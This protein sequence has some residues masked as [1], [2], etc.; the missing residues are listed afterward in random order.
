MTAKVEEALKEFEKIVPNI[1]KQL[2][3]VQ[4][5]FS[6]VNITELKKKV[7]KTTDFVKSKL[8][9]I[10]KDNQNNEIT[11]KVNNQEAIKQ[12][13]QL[14]KEI[15]SLQKKISEREIKLK[16]TNSTLDSMRENTKQGVIAEMPDAGTKRINQQTELRLFSDNNYVKMANESDKLANEITRYNAQLDSAKD[17]MAGMKNEIT[18]ISMTQDQLSNSAS[19][20]TGKIGQSKTN[21][22]KLKSNFD[23]ISKITQNITNNIKSVESGFKNGLKNVIKYVA[24]LFSLRSIYSAL[25]SSANNWLSSQDAGAKQLS[26]NIDYMKYAM[27]S[28]LAPVIQFVTNLV[29]Q[30]MKA[31]QSVAYA[32]TG[33]NI[34]AKASANSYANMASSAKK[35]KNETKQ[36]AG[37]HSEIN[38][39]SDSNSDSG[40]DGSTAP[41]FD[42]SGI[43]N[44]PNSIM[45][46]I[47]NGNWYEVGATIGE[48]LNDAMN[49]I[50]WDKIKNTAKSIGTG[51]AQFLNGFIATTDW[52]KVGNT[53]AQGI[54]TIIDFGYNFVTTFNWKEFGKAIGNT[55]N[56]FFSSIEWDTLAKTLSYGI[57]GILDSISGFAANIDLKEVV[58]SVANFIF[59]IDWNGLYKS[60][61]GALGSIA[62]MIGKGAVGLLQEVWKKIKDIFGGW[63]TDS[64]EQGN[65]IIDGLLQGILNPFASIKKWIEENIFQPFIN[66]F[67]DAFGIHSPSTVMAEQGGYIIQGLLNGMSSWIEK[68]TEIW[69]NIK[70]TAIEKLNDLKISVSGKFAEI[71]SKYEEWTSNTKAVISTWASETK[72]KVTDAWSNISANVGNKVENL[73]E[74]IFI[75]LEKAKNIVSVW[76]NN[77]KS[78]ITMSWS[79]SSQNVENEINNLKSNIDNG[80]NNAERMVNN[81]G[82]TIENAFLK[83]GRNAITWGKDLASNMAS[84]IKN[85]INKVTNAVSSVAGKIKDYLHFTEPDTGPLSDFHTYMPDMIDLMVSGIKANTNKV[86]DEIENLA[87]TMSYTINTEAI[88]GNPLTSTSIKPIS[89][90]SQGNIFE[91]IEDAISFRE[92]R[93]PVHVTIQYFGKEVFDETID[94]INSKTRRTGRNTIVTVGD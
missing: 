59:N 9:K 68:V 1:K 72:S 66:G 71:K 46:A 35:A 54:N 88:T 91:N 77:V 67:K 90:Q 26:A 39:I 21:T 73:K 14:Q 87:G 62:G 78:K 63:K 57:E 11:I 92:N 7:E 20:F 48:K 5:V 12:T 44:T 36:L 33:V 23:G 31:I 93:Q 34:F 65:N 6:Q 37:I 4:E 13:T 94:Y 50:P 40:S 60:F 80:L 51:I 27:G 75:G 43:D 64:E 42:L 29:Y 85:N 32:L 56:G 24:A 22:A 79:S 10:K 16:I 45:D 8:Q 52:G 41:N 53:F 83:L 30:L 18:S 86:K 81:W 89:V 17:I 49:N 3:Q 74:N 84:G 76:G 15:E 69:N 19:M 61:Y 55:I 82:N 25:S 28:A 2:K 38:N 70:N 47:K 58:I